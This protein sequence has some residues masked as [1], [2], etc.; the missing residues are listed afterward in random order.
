MQRILYLVLALTLGLGFA[1]CKK[2]TPQPVTPSEETPIQLSSHLTQGHWEQVLLAPDGD[3]RLTQRFTFLRD[4]RYVYRY[5]A[6][7]LTGDHRD[8]LRAE[9]ND[10]YYLFGYYSLEGERVTLLSSSFGGYAERFVAA[11]T[12]ASQEADNTF[13]GFVLLLDP[14]TRALRFARELSK[15]DH[16]L[17]KTIDAYRFVYRK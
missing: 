14:S 12:E 7:Q 2:D 6:E 8:D 13:R 9:Y 11:R 15:T 3:Q 5:I 16:P 17:S 1:S 4:G 10:E